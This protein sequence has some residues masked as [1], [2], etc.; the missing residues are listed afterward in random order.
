MMT[1]R[2]DRS[3]Q[4]SALLDDI[5]RNQEQCIKNLHQLLDLYPEV[6]PFWRDQDGTPT[7]KGWYVGFRVPDAQPMAVAPADELA[8]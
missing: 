1:N 3:I 4:A 2:T 5:A 8:T 6:E 7:P